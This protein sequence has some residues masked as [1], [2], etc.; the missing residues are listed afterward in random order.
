MIFLRRTLSSIAKKQSSVR[1]PKL[2]VFDLDHTLWSFGIDSMCFT[3]PF[4]LDQKTGKIIDMSSKPIEYF[5]D[6][7]KVL[8]HLK[9]LNVP[10]AV[11]SRSKYPSGAY[12]LLELLKMNQYIK[13]FEIYPGPKTKHFGRLKEQTGVP[14]SDMIFFDDEPRNINDISALGVYSVLVDHDNGATE[15]V[16]KNSFINFAQQASPSNV[17][18]ESS[19]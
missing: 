3:P 4:H 16:V 8:Q 14:Y 5:V 13:Y 2:A 18:D 11:A 17:D 7:P 15:S 9:S 12:A 1:F 6:T 19:N 10:V